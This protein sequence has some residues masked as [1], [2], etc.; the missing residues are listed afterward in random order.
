MIATTVALLLTATPTPAPGSANLWVE[1]EQF[2]DR[3]GWLVESQFIEQMGSSYLLAQGLSGPAADAV[4]QVTPPRAGRYAGWARTRNWVPDMQPAPGRWQLLVGGQASAELGTA[5]TAEWVWQRAGTWDLPAAPT[6]LRL[7]DLTGEYGRCDVLLLSTDLAFEPAP[8]QAAW[9]DLRAAV[10]DLDLTPREGGAR[11]VVVVGGGVAGA[12]AAIAAARHGASVALIQDRPVLGGN[13]SEEVR[14]GVAGA[15][16][17]QMRGWREGG[18]VEEAR[19]EALAHGN[20]SKGLAAMAAA[21]P[22]LAL[23]LST[24]CSGAMVVDGQITAV[25]GIEALTSRRLTVRGKL[26][27]DATGDGT[28]GA[29]AG[30]EYRVGREAREVY[31]E[32]IAPA[33]ADRQT[34]GST[35]LYGLRDTGIAAPFK[36]P[37]WAR[38][39]PDEAS[40]PHRNH[41]GGGAF[42]W[43]E[44]GNRRDTIADAELIRDE[45]LK[46]VYGVWDHLK[47]HCVQ[48]PE[49]ER[50]AFSWVGTVAGK[51]ESRRLLGDYVM[52]Q[53]DIQGGRRFADQVAYGGWPIDLHV[54]IDDPGPPNIFVG[55]PLYTIPFRSLYSRNIGNLLLAGR[56]ISVSHVALGSV[57]V[58]ATCGLMGQAAG[59][60]AAFCAATGLSPRQLGQQRIGELQQ[61]LLRD[62]AGLL[63]LPLRELDNLAQRATVTA[64]SS[65]A[66]RPFRREQ[67][68]PATLHTGHCDR[69][70]IL[71][72]PAGRLR[73]ATLLLV[74]SSQAP[75]PATVELR[76]L[77][78][79]VV[80]ATPPVATLTRPVPPGRHWVQFDLDADLGGAPWLAVILRQAK[81]LSWPLT[82]NAPPHVSRA[83]YNPGAQ[84]WNPAGEFYC[85]VTD[86]APP[87][88]SGA[89]AAK[90]TDGWSR[91]QGDDYAGWLSDPAQPLPAHVELRWPTPQRVTRVE[92][93]FDPN[94]DE[95]YPRKLVAPELVRDYRLLGEVEGQWVELAAVRDNY[96]PFRRHAW[97][98]QRLSALRL[99]ILRTGGDPAARVFELRAYER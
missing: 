41:A 93:L 83:W 86:P 57:R 21:E 48:S 59:T 56:D 49:F 61:R 85:V 91:A 11:E 52:T 40:L 3:G 12:L 17:N 24:R 78:A 89:A 60:A 94:Y 81:E 54:D 88:V 58:M 39:F 9:A 84:D 31:D 44:Y 16:I 37:A 20:W 18:L 53:H 70:A 74:N 80:T 7:R 47:N 73:T 82:N 28:L 26:F 5:P 10:S 35:L 68:Q 79:G 75:L 62:D 90:V 66:S 33:T 15:A 38:Q 27:V 71:P 55:V 46:I 19:R 6:E 42:W 51:R 32:S 64:S 34:L 50:H 69:A 65:V 14:V 23:F 13:A 4:T 87:E 1:A 8:G 98:A 92:V 96:Q 45:L 97:A 43:C 30:A 77:A 22:R 67:V 25:E 29:L 95:Q 99:E 72:A 63:D 36:P 2:A 76:P